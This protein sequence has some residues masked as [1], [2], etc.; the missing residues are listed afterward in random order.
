MLR[1]NGVT[2]HFWTRLSA[3]ALTGD[4]VVDGKTLSFSEGVLMAV[5]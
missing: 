5:S 4:V 2:W 3:A 1:R